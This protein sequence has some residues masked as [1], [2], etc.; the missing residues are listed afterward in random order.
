M[1]QQ[2]I[3]NSNTTKTKKM[4]LLIGLGLNRQQIADLLGVRYGFVQNVWQKVHGT[5]RFAVM[6]NLNA[7]QQ[8]FQFRFERPYGIEIEAYN[9]SETRLNEMFQNFN[10]GDWQMK[11][12][13]SINGN[14]AKEIVSPKLKGNKGIEQLAKV[15]ISLDKTKAKVNSSCGLHIHIDVSDYSLEDWKRLIINYIRLEDFIDSLM[16][17]G[18]R[19]NSNRYCQSIKVDGFE[20]K[21]K[22]ASDL[23]DIGKKL[24]YGNDR[25]RKLNTVSY[26]KHRT[27]EFRQH[28]G[29]TDYNKISNW[30]MFLTRLVEFSKSQLIEDASEEQLA[31]FCDETT[32]NYL[33]FRKLWLAS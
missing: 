2:E 17:E 10:L 25:Y 23:R 15:C 3:L 20:R 28:S 5:G 33:K 31:R 8:P 4:E 6:L 19:G 13:S 7:T 32:I 12:D 29:T 21:V 22:S 1:T 26:W 14:L 18:R 24:G 30:I 11:R 9:V 16:P 27:V